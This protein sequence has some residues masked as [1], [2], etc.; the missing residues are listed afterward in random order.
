MYNALPEIC[1]TVMTRI[2]KN[3]P[4]ENFEAKQEVEE[5]KGGDKLSNGAVII[6]TVG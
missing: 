5:S 6:N 2:I 4:Y 3:A 1:S